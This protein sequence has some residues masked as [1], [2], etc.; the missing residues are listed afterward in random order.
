MPS[1]PMMT[2]Y[3]VNLDPRSIGEF[4]NHVRWNIY[5]YILNK[6][7]LVYSSSLITIIYYLISPTHH[8]VLLPKVK[9]NGSS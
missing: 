3:Y 4:S 7:K 9:Y 5:I 6:E 8:P 1:N 2:D